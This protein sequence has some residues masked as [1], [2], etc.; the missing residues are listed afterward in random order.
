MAPKKRRISSLIESQLPGFITTEYENF[1]KFVEKYYEHLESAGQPLDIISNLDK[2]R[3]I[4]YYEENLLNQS[5]RLSSNI[6]AD[7]TTVTVDDATSF[8]EE[9]G[10]IKIGSE[11]LFYQTRT[12]TQFLEV[13]RGVSGNTTLGDLYESSSFVTTA[14]GPHYTGDTVYNVSN[15][16]LY[17]LVKN[18]EQTYLGSFPEAYLK[19]EV[20]KRTLIKNI[21]NFY[22]AKGTDR[23]VKFIFNSII[24]K[25]PSD[26]PEIYN[27][28]DFTLK[29]STSDWTKDYSLKVKISNGDPNSLIGNTITQNLDDYDTS[30][31]FASAVVDN[32]IFIGNDGQDD[33][34]QLILEPSTV[35]GRFE[36]Y[37]RTT[38]TKTVPSSY[39]TGDRITVKSTLG[40]PKQGKLLIGDEVITYNDKN[41]TQF[42]I[43][44]RLG[45]IRNHNSNKTVYRYSTI[46]SSSV[47]LITLGLIYNLS[48]INAAPYSSSGEM[49]QVSEP[50][51]ET[52]DP[53][54]FDRNIGR[55]RWLINENPI[56]N[57]AE[58]KGVESPFYS[59]VATV[60]EDEQYFYICS[61]SYPSENILVN[62]NYNVT[63]SDQKHLKLIRKQPITTTEVYPTTNRDV[64]IF[65]DGVPALGYKDNESIKYG[66][67]V[68]S[69]ITNKGV[70]YQAPPFVLINET[71][72]K[73][74]AILS[75]SVV[76]SIEILTE[77]VFTEDPEV[78]ITSGE[79]AVLRPVITNG[80][81][82]SMDVLDPGQYYSS[83]PIIR[84]VDTLGKGNFA[85]YEAVLDPNGSIIEARKIAG[86]RFY[87]RGNTIVTVEPVGKNATA[88]ASIKEWVFNRYEK[89]KNNLDSDNGTV[90]ASFDPSKNY[91]YAYVAN[92]L[93]VRKRSYVSL[94]DFT[95][96]D[97]SV[98]S[99]IV[100]YAYDG[101]P[102]YGPYGYEDPTDSSSN[103][104]RLS[105]G[106]Q[107][108]NSRPSGPDTGRY[109]LGSF[110]DD[111][112][113]VPSVNSGKTELD[114]NNGRFC[115]T[116]DYPNGVY[117]YFIT[118]DSSETPVFP[119]ILGVNYYSLPVD[120]N[121]NSSISQ[122]DIPRTLKS[123]RSDVSERNGSGFIGLI[124]DVKNGNITSGYVESSLP[125][126]SPGNVV[127]LNNFETGG[128][129]ASVVVN[130]VTGKPISSIESIQTKANRISIQE[131]AYLFDN[132][133]ITQTDADG[134]V[135]ANGRLVGDVFNASEL[136]LRNVTGQF[137]SIRPIDSSTQ[138]YRLVLNIDSNFTVNSTLVL[139]NDDDEVIA[140]GIILETIV[141]QNSVKVK[142]TSGDFIV[143]EDYYLRSSNLSD[144]NRA[145][146][147]SLESLSRDLTPFNVQE[148]IA[149][150]QT[151]QPH[152]LGVGDS[153][154]IDVI[155]NDAVSETQYYVRKR[156]YQN[157]VALA[158]SHTSN[159]IDQGIGSADVLNSGRGY[160]VGT[161]TDVEL[162][163]QDVNKARTNIGKPGDLNNA[164]A[165]IIV[166]NPG[167]NG[168][169]VTS[170]IITSK[171]KGYRKGDV[172]T[173]DDD[174]LNRN[175]SDTSPQR[176]VLEVDHVGFAAN[177]TVL[178][179]SNV[180]NISQDDYLQISQEI[181]KVVSV[182]V[183][184]KEVVVSRGQQ[185]TVPL[186]HYN[187][188]EV[189]LKDGFYR[190]DNNFRPFGSD[191]LKPFL[192]SYDENTQNINVAFEY[193]VQNPQKL[194]ISSTF[195]D[196]SLPKKLVKFRSVDEANFKLEFSTDNSNFDTNPIIEI[197]KYYKYNFDVGH[198]SM[199]D[200]YLDFSSSS[201]YNIF[202]EE[203]EVS[204]IAPG[205]SGSFV[206]IKLGF[207]PAIASNTYQERKAVNFQNYFYFIKVSPDVDTGR[208]YLKIVDDPLA[209]TKNVIYTTANK[210]VYELDKTPSYDGSGVMSYTT[211]ARNAIG[212]IKSVR[213]VN[214][215]ENYKFI[216][217]VFGVSP[218]ESN[219]AIVDPIWDPI[220]KDVLGFNILEQGNNYSNPIIVM[221]DGDGI[222]FEYECLVE[223]GKIRQIK[224]IKKGSSFT[225]KPTFKVVESNV[226][227]YMESNNIGSP[228]NVKITNPGRGFNSDQSQL[229]TYKSPTTF[230]LR[231]ISGRFFAG[232]KIIQP[233][234]NA[235]AIV[236]KDGWREGSNLLK[237]QK[238]TGVF[239]N[240]TVIKSTKDNGR[241]G[242]L[243]AQ[244]STEFK[245]EIKSYVD[246][247]GYFTSDRGKLSNAN[248]RLQDSYFYQDYSYV[249]KSKSSIEA[250]RNLIK[251]TTHPAGF[252]MFGE[253]VIDSKAESQ[254]PTE[255]QPI[256]HFSVI[257]L[258]PI[259]ITSI[260][261]SKILTVVQYKLESLILEDGIGS[262]SVD[263]F[264]TSETQ[265]FDVKLSP[266]FNGDFDPDTGQ[267]IGNTSFTL[268]NRANNTAVSLNNS[269]Q[270]IVTLD[271]IFQEPGVSY[272]VS[273][274]NIIFSA[275]PLGKRIV[276]GQEVEAVKFYGR[277]I[278]FKTPS[279]SSRYFRKVKSIA[280]QFDGV[281]F[282][283]DLYWEDDNSLVKT[284]PKENL[285]VALNS[286]V[287]KA[288][289]TEKEPFGNSYSII[290]SEDPA[291]TD[292]IRF[293]KPPVDNEDLYGPPEEIPESLKN[294]E[295]CFIYSVGSY[296]RLTINSNLYEYR[297]AGPYLIQDEVT[298]SIRKIDE[299]RYALVFIDGVLQR[300]VDAYQIVGPNITFT[301]NLKVYQ[302]PNGDRI[303][304]D[305]NIILMYGRDVAK[306]LTFYDFEPYTFN[307]TL[308][309]TLEGDDISSK[310]I[311]LYNFNSLSVNYFKQDDTIVGKVIRYTEL[312][313]D[314]IEI[315][316]QNPKNISLNQNE[317]TL[318]NVSKNSQETV[319]AGNY[320]ISY[321]Y[322]TDSDG[323]RVL[324]R[325][326]PSWLYGSQLGNVAW[327]NKNSMLGN[328]LPGDRI[329]IDGE[330]DFRT[331]IS[332]PDTTKT[333]SYRDG[334]LVQNEYYAN[335]K[336]TNYEGDTQGEGLSI[337]ANVNSFGQIT[338]LN[339]SDV[340]WNQRDLDL[341]FEQGILLQPTA[342]EYYTTP[343][344]HFI[345][346]DGN[347]GGAKAEVIAYGGQILDVVLI[348]GGSGYTAPPKVVVSRRYKRI[349]ELSRK[350]D[351]LTVLNIG[352]EISV[353]QEIVSDSQ[354]TITGAG[355]ISGF[356]SVATFGGFVAGINSDIDITE[357]VLPSPKIV[358][359]TDKKFVSEFT[360]QSPTIEVYY[361]DR[362]I[363]SYVSVVIGGVY[364]FE[365]SASIQTISV[366]ELTSIFQIK[367]N[368]AF[369]QEKA[370]SV[371]GIGTFLDA[372]MDLNDVIAFV[373]NT[374]RFPD[375]P[376]RLRIGR[377]VIYYTNKKQDRFLGLTRG[378][379][380]SPLETHN[381]GDLVLHYPE[382]ITIVSGGINT[383]LSEGS[384][385]S[386]DITV[387]EQK[388]SIQSIIEVK[389][390]EESYNEIDVKLQVESPKTFQPKALP[391]IAI[392]PRDS[393]NIVTETYSSVS[394]IT[395]IN[396]PS[397]QV[398]GSVVSQVVTLNEREIQLTSD[399]QIQLDTSAVITSVSIGNIAATISSSSALV[400]S[401][402][403]TSE[404]T[405]SP[406]IQAVNTFTTFSTQIIE[407][408]QTSDLDIQSYSSTVVSL[409]SFAG[410]V[411]SLI[412]RETVN[413]PFVMYH[414]T[415]LTATVA[416]INTF[417]STVT[418]LIGGGFA[419]GSTRETD[420][421]FSYV[422]FLIEEYV[423][424]NFIVQR[425]NN[426]VNLDTPYNEVFN[427][428]GSSITVDNKNQYSPEGFEDY[429]LGNAGL[430]LDIYESTAFVDTGINYG[431][432]IN[433][434][435]LIYSGLT[436]KDFE[437][438]SNSAF[439][440]N[441][442]R[443]NFGIPTYQT[444]VTICAAGGSIGNTLQVQNTDYFSNPSV[445]GIPV[446]YLFTESG[447]VL[448]YTGLTQ[449]TFTGI[450]VVRGPASININ[451]DIIP[452][453][454]V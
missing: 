142:L 422:D 424:E 105:S 314:K 3:D 104:V 351:S 217:T 327:S 412:S 270:L 218:A 194:S 181:V 150:V 224:V 337:T 131:S 119:Y 76:D 342:Y 197:Q 108:K 296:E 212:Q 416:D 84:I 239:E 122:D 323:E 98:H 249:V 280:N 428:N 237:V 251:E 282:E 39:S 93:N 35:N 167:V 14:A 398:V 61:S 12:D 260:S 28:K 64:G 44:T 213:V 234:T 46:S 90:F 17:A 303:T 245:P 334:D 188:A 434:V 356:I 411:T 41:A 336:T 196:E 124:Q 174:D 231:N 380:G 42:I 343:E 148:N 269:Q 292:K 47:R 178:K 357:I 185:N 244:L 204:T 242:T 198:P 48:P 138:V 307:N 202:T 355:D 352:T 65:I 186:N 13:S 378:Y 454:I 7:S 332:T 106:Y 423:L 394:Y 402:Y 353:K 295:K 55:T 57:F 73:A 63:L 155:P 71:P 141:R 228:R 427:R 92:P 283:F 435:D 257:E 49:I 347:G 407:N 263:T 223:L 200:T 241:F 163:F 385:S 80:S 381:A 396:A 53:I 268:I 210:F 443:F 79:G 164:K 135:L 111:Y 248:Q 403:E 166:S 201:N 439:T 235:T 298:G 171:G 442:T 85:E 146:I 220:S 290:R 384:V 211:T 287:Q 221:S 132:D 449:T 279:L 96:D 43:D 446:H 183:I 238:I 358:R 368:K 350:V 182:D 272:T 417:S 426:V 180:N 140:Q 129:G 359:M 127:Y 354:I 413:D 320:T 278:K 199:G 243:Y 276:E 6:L 273:G 369:R 321:Y 365:S 271:G 312:N 261:T 325:T 436:I 326:I 390:F 304:Q 66:K 173:V 392:I 222:G 208:S 254:M 205:N 125:I 38:T 431:T 24:A 294:Y 401:S 388:T 86:G 159:I 410:N 432:S 274:S 233:S 433:D 447:T 255:Q 157:A 193:S 56:T 168:S 177:N 37:G 31:T 415:E 306:S 145:E 216:P 190:F 252:L 315:L 275:P 324:E 40:F 232:E 379:Q 246:N 438:R 409:T 137:N 191:M 116:P 230:V 215:G 360:V 33:L 27:P 54:A 158:P 162:I 229:S 78:R 311:K 121:Y 45:P 338:T 102:I 319:L 16:F 316:F 22:K 328:L 236:A 97:G 11:V 418:M 176:L 376:S 291:V 88:R 387:L 69:S 253:M 207:G 83:P 192:I 386:S 340:D 1:S 152:N 265:T 371:N 95:S 101:N 58:I 161:Y 301:Q 286:V 393:Y 240:G 310:F 30:I 113:W 59:D 114:Q 440:S 110:I 130:E 375:T 195:F 109:P 322:K 367:A 72:N 313:N 267:L 89:L 21:S 5:T 50:G 19:G 397:A 134:A 144:T 391:W 333:K 9:N 259:Q 445:T 68:S 100:G 364:G 123:I 389:Q 23:S 308:I 420:Y 136:V 372:P 405:L 120:S 91:G 289:L 395:P 305:V 419:S 133:L 128:S 444:P 15:L 4:N 258:D 285:I 184:K 400:S 139:R 10:Y 226:K 74:R 170:V 363:D 414:N 256:S 441:G 374:E 406:Q 366:D 214:T 345:P 149:I 293:S 450:S 107:I 284:D 25:E 339:V 82:T 299:P 370:D 147:I 18:F 87:T 2:Y 404:I 302:D 264:D 329:L 318:V 160:G 425:S 99:P 451:D 300:D 331:I 373:P 117:A 288:R 383:I 187:D 437:I 51:F 346:V 227:I 77:E 36:V 341:Y 247:V 399:Q 26:V 452:F 209:G 297:F 430:T 277:A 335:T 219:E 250:W 153:V 103:I 151:S 75:G 348:D 330:N 169:T 361:I 382:F 189:T 206:S 203:K 70:S 156:L 62:T 126:H 349:K 112:R 8:P 32:V 154:N 262:V 94:T 266:E 118:I 143:T 377:E 175:V 309:V 20:D 172:L 281:Q 453:T 81:I 225:Y 115:V 29:S 408:V 421:R 67:I 165:T 317:L 362:L 34:Y 60:L 179:L 429:T 344:I 52:L 448:S